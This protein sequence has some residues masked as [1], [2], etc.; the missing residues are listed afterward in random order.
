MPVLSAA[1]RSRLLAAAGLGV[2][3]ATVALGAAPA[4]AH[5]GSS[6][7]AGDD[8]PEPGPV[9]PE[10]I[11]ALEAFRARIAAGEFANAGAADPVVGPTSVTSPNVKY[12]GTIPQTTDGVGARV[13]GNRLFVTSTKDLQIFDIT[14]PTIP[15]RMG[16][17]AVNVEFENEEVPTDGKVLGISGQ[18]P[19]VNSNGVCVGQAILRGCIALYDVRG[20]APV[21]IQNVVDVGDH[22]ST[23]IEVD[24]NTCAYMYGSSGS[25]T[26]L[27][28]VLATPRVPATKLAGNWQKS[29]RDRGFPVASGH[30]QTQVRPGVLLTATIPTYLVSVNAADGGSIEMPAVLGRADFSGAP[31]DKTRFTHGVEWARGGTD[32]IMLSGGET[33]FTVT[34]DPE[35]GAFSTFVTGGTPNAP[36]FAFADQ[37]RPKAGNFLDGN[38]PDGSFKLGCSVHWFK[39]HAT[40]NNGGLVALAQYENGVKFERV[41]SNGKIT[42]VGFFLPLGGATS[43]PHWAPDGKTVYAVDYQRGLDIIQYNGELFVGGGGAEPVVPEVPL[44]ALLPLGALLLFAGAYAVRSRA[45]AG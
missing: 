23:C 14:D 39:P 37:V 44:A 4:L 20:S 31:D 26:D 6:V 40:F 36:T 33:N 34:C 7:V 24:G 32:K 11:A 28:G 21:L 16:S 2:L 19:T 27:R 29:L 13:V 42:E 15:S 43:A 38:S 10:A 35:A 9:T 30:H 22:T 17:I 12:I 1:R 18:T 41:E 5:D 25:I 8:R 3:V 45:L